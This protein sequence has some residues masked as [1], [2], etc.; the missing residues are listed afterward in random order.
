MFFKRTF[1]VTA[2]AALLASC[3]GGGGGSTPTSP[4]SGGPQVIVVQIKDN[5]FSPKDVVINPGDTVRWVMAG[6]AKI[7][8]VTAL[9]GSFDSGMAFPQTGAT[10][11]RTFSTP[12]K[13]YEYQCKSHYGCCQMAGAVRVGSNAPNPNPGY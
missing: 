5:E 1:C 13:T 11:E 6:S 2:L 12:G 8:T 4:G 10:F 3:G 7:H 9:D